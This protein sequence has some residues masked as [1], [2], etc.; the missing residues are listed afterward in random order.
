M[1]H[2]YDNMDGGGITVID[3]DTTSDRKTEK[4]KLWK[5][6]IMNDDYTPMDFVVIILMEYFTK[7]SDEAMELTMEVHNKGSAVAGVYTFE[8]AETKLSLVSAAARKNEYPLMLIIE[9]IID[10]DK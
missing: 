2:I 1:T 7:T 10:D 9:P 6:V 8:V 3:R 4:P 5:V